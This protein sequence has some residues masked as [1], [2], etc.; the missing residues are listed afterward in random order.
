M[1]IRTITILF[2]LAGMASA[3]ARDDL[4][5]LPPTSTPPA[6]PA[7]EE[8]R[9]PSPV[10]A[11]RAPAPSATITITPTRR[12][13]TLKPTETFY[14]SENEWAT[15]FASIDQT[16]TAWAGLPTHTASPTK[17]QTAAPTASPIPTST[18]TSTPQPPLQAHTWE[19]K[20]VLAQ[21]FTGHG[22]GCCFWS[23]PPELILYANGLFIRS[24]NLGKFRF[25]VMERKLKRQEM[26]RLLNA[27]DQAGFL[28]YE[29]TI[30]RDPMDGL[31][32]TNIHVNAWKSMDVWGQILG[33]WIY[34][35]SDWWRKECPDAECAD[36]PIILPALS[37][38]FKLLDK[39]DPG[40]LTRFSPS[41]MM[42]WVFPP[43]EWWYSEEDVMNPKKW[44]VSQISLQ[45]LYDLASANDNYLAIIDDPAVVR[46]L[47]AGMV[48]G[49]YRQGDLTAA[50]F[51]RPLLPYEK[52]GGYGAIDPQPGEV[53]PVGT[54]LSCSPEDGVLPIP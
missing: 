41:Q 40:G 44:L 50:V 49:V 3:C 53:V 24:Q 46:A 13:I 27:I 17:T 9:T 15:R 34:E 36:P 39:Y 45:E 23:N 33:Y 42:V 31:P 8:T 1:S 32:S 18:L 2:L 4:S 6:A 14:I 21:V 25:Q 11:T 52:P 30:Y 29:P 35:G 7:P 12:V 5:R 38:T 26:C 22:D 10:A 19:V 37:N 43:E 48:S 20:P 16:E 51:M 47:D 28:D 54:T